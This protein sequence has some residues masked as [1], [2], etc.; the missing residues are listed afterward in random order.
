MEILTKQQLLDKYDAEMQERF[1]SE[2]I[3]F[4][5]WQHLNGWVKDLTD[6]YVRTAQGK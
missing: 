5:E 2:V 4:V 1:V 6:T 3:P